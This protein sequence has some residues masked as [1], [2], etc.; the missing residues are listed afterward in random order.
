MV[1]HGDLHPFNLLADIDG[2][3]TVLDWTAA[4]VAP[5]AYDVAATW[6]LLRYPPLEAPAALRP[7][8]GAGA[9]C[10][11]AG[12][13]AGTT[14]ENPTADLT[15]LDWYTALHAIRVLIDLAIV[16]T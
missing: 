5:P 10:S 4:A 6:L 14:L 3:V 12:S 9:A 16:A 15:H 2:G 8:I 13:C 11:P 1:C 7:V